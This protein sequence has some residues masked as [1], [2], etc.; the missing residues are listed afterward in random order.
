MFSYSVSQMFLFYFFFTLHFDAAVF[1]WVVVRVYA[2]RLLY[3]HIHE[4]R[5]FV[6]LLALRGE[7]GNSSVDCFI[8]FLFHG[9]TWIMGMQRYLF[10][11]LF[12]VSDQRCSPGTFWCVV[13]FTAEVHIHHGPAARLFLSFVDYCLSCIRLFLGVALS[14]EGRETLIHIFLQWGRFDIMGCDASTLTG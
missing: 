5:A 14:S 4:A 10:L 6:L 7:S 9:T 12:F 2:T 3:L 11:L 8:L 1:L 13:Y